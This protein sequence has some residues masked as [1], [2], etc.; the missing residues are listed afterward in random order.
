MPATSFVARHANRYFGASEQTVHLT[1]QQS[2]VVYAIA[3]GP[4]GTWV[5]IADDDYPAVWYPL[6]YPL[7]FFKIVDSRLS[8]SWTSAT[9]VDFNAEQCAFRSF[10]D[11]SLNPHFY[12]RLVDKADTELTIFKAQKEFMDLEYPYSYGFKSLIT[13]DLTWCQCP[14]CEHVWEDEVHKLGMKRCPQCGSI[15]VDKLWGE[16]D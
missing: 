10:E 1:P 5:Y 3:E 2:Y 13:F 15:L 8:Q 16:H 4:S 12:E 9:M 11:W 7:E 6:A 14:S